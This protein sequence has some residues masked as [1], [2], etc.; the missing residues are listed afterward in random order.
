MNELSCLRQV[1][2]CPSLLV[3]GVPMKDKE[4]YGFTH[5]WD[6]KLNATHKTKNS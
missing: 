2:A 4:P 1:K 3:A 5:M 6:I